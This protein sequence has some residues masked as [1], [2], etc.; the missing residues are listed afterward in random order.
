MTVAA[1]KILAPEPVSLVLRVTVDVGKTRV[2]R[3]A[4]N[5]RQLIAIVDADRQTVTAPA[6]L[7]LQHVT[8]DVVKSPAKKHVKTVEIRALSV[9]VR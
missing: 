4:R 6:N 7:V 2:T 5:A 8:V 1:A 3:L 9:T